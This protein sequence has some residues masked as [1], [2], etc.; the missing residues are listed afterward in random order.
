MRKWIKTI[1]TDLDHFMSNLRQRLVYETNH[2]LN[3]IQKE[4]NISQEELTLYLKLWTSKSLN[5]NSQRTSHE[6][7]KG[8][9]QILLI[10]M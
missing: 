3:N 4:S 1:D 7:S 6:G 10:S 8:L 5:I 2:F 9:S